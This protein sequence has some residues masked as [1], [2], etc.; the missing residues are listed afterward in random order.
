VARESRRL[1]G[2]HLNFFQ[3]E[4]GKNLSGQTVPGIHLRVQDGTAVRAQTS[5][6]MQEYTVEWRQSKCF[7]LR[8]AETHQQTGNQTLL[9]GAKLLVRPMFVHGSQV[10]WLMTSSSQ[11]LHLGPTCHSPTHQDGINP[12]GKGL[13]QRGDWMVKLDLKDAYLSVPLH[14]DHRQFVAFS[15]RWNGQ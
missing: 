10:R 15:C 9:Y 3:T 4:L 11:S 7:G 12:D 6:R 2:G 8:T 14:L 5:G 13:L 1:V